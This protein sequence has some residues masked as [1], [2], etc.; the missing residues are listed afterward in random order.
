MEGFG[1]ILNGTTLFKHVAKF[2]LIADRGSKPARE[3]WRIIGRV[4]KVL[5]GV[6]FVRME[7]NHTT[8]RLLPSPEKGNGSCQVSSR[9]TVRHP[10]FQKD[11]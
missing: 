2:Q 9:Q 10:R 1:S 3:L 4:V 8:H 11:G 7:H 5:S 6:F